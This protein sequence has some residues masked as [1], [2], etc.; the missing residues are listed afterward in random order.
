MLIGKTGNDGADISRNIFGSPINLMPESPS[1]VALIKQWLK[2]CEVEHGCG[3]SLPPSQMPSM[4][5][6]VSDQDKIKLVRVPQDL[7]ERYISLSYCWG[8]GSQSV[9]LNKS[10]QSDLASG[11]SVR[12]LDP[13]IRDSITVTRQLGFRYLWIDALCIFQDDYE[14]KARELGRMGEIYRDAT[15]T[16][17]ASAAKD[18]NDGFLTKRKPN[19]TTTSSKYGIP[20]PVFKGRFE[21][22]EN[23]IAA[24]SV[25]LRPH[26][27]DKV[28]PW[29][30]R[31][32]TLQE[33]LFSGR[34]LQYRAKQTTWVCYCSEK[35]AQQCDG[36]VPGEGNTLRS[37]FNQS[38]VSELFVNA[39][40]ILRKGN[41]IPPDAKVLPTWY[42]L[43]AEYTSRKL[44]YPTDRLPAISG[45]AKEFGSAL[46]DQYVCGLW[47]S[48]LPLG[49]IWSPRQRSQH[50]SDSRSGPSW[51][52]VSH[53]KAIRWEYEREDRWANPDFEVLGIMVDLASPSEPFGEIKTAELHVRGLF[54]F[55][56]PQARTQDGTIRLTLE[57]DVSVMV[58]FDY[59]NDPRVKPGSGF[60]LGLLVVFD[61]GQTGV[62]G[63]V[64]VKE[65]EEQYSRVGYFFV[66]IRQPWEYFKNG[67]EISKTER[68]PEECQARVRSLW[69]GEENIREIVLV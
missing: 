33:M 28:E 8:K 47:K 62:G 31:A 27:F 61:E 40:A 22:D 18:V 19:L 44:T 13:T 58:F 29:Y 4:I 34:R 53:E 65:E 30:D 48:D 55:S 66:A 26:M 50:T 21:G 2:K 63:L 10:N 52:W 3:I 42:G 59:T 16:I 7:R 69:G 56:S 37:L 38:D 1:T 54:M 12:Q 23:S 14:F 11:V 15:F 39:M 6:D 60:E 5:L 64:L 45:I 68:S 41:S 24:S 43:V 20:G 32:W 17:V 49:L 67:H 25:T 46:G 57:D 36:W 51:S 9:M 35:F